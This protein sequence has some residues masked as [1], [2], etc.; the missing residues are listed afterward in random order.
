MGTN[1]LNSSA[2]ITAVEDVRAL[3]PGSA[4]YLFTYDPGG[5][6]ELT[7][8]TLPM[9]GICVGHLSSIGPYWRGQAK[10][11]KVGHSVAAKQRGLGAGGGRSIAPPRTIV[12]KIHLPRRTVFFCNI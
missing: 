11:Q 4:S 8:V 6:G 7:Q 9:A 3:S 10:R 5:S 12:L 1:W 2:R